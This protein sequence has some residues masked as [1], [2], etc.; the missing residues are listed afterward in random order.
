MSCRPPPQVYRTLISR[1]PIRR[2]LT[3]DPEAP[4]R[5][6]LSL[7][8]GPVERVHPPKY[9][10]K[11]APSSPHHCHADATQLACRRSVLYLLCHGLTTAH[12]YAT[13]SISISPWLLISPAHPCYRLPIT[14]LNNLIATRNT[15]SGP[16][17]LCA[18]LRQIRPV[19]SQ[20]SLDSGHPAAPSV[21]SPSYEKGRMVQYGALSAI[22][23]LRSGPHVDCGGYAI[24]PKTGAQ[25][26]R[27]WTRFGLE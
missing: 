27:I 7:S 18:F 14:Y 11:P 23:S 6:V 22:S 24:A 9:R 25:N 17:A 4:L 26:Y 12:R 16:P 21:T 13:A 3:H 8:N 1:P 15:S 2:A 5:L 20:L 10:P 19:R